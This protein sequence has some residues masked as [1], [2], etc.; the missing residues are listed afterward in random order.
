MSEGELLHGGVCP[1]CG[2]EFGDG[3]GD[4]EEGDQIEDVRMCVIEKNDEDEIGESI[5]HLP[6]EIE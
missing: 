5:I 6:E 3:W 2:E 4:F 1:V